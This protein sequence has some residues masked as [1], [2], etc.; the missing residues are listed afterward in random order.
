MR[1]KLNSNKILFFYKVDCLTNSSI[2]I[3]FDL[4]FS[5]ILIKIG[6]KNKKI[7][8]LERDKN[9]TK[10]T[11]KKQHNEKML[12]NNYSKNMGK[13]KERQIVVIE[14]SHDHDVIIDRNA[15]KYNDKE[16]LS[17]IIAER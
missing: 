8:M 12:K 3:N 15:K 13:I 4:L 6:K 1:K 5:L 10:Q 7:N 14:E 11:K 9:K 17:T 2:L 16:S